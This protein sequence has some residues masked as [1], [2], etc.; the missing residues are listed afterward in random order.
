MKHFKNISLIAALSFAFILSSCSGI[1]GA[2]DAADEL[3]FQAEDLKDQRVQES[4]GQEL[5]MIRVRP[6]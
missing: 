4:G 6:E 3:L 5:R 2:N 1:T